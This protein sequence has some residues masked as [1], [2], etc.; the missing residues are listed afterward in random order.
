MAGIAMLE[1]WTITSLETMDIYDRVTGDCLVSLD[2]ITDVSLKNTEDKS[3]VKGKGGNVLFIIKK[4]KGLTGSGKSAYISGNLMAIQTGTDGVAG[5]ITFKKRDITKVLSAATTVLTSE[6]ADGTV[7]AEIT[8]LKVTIGDVTTAYTQATTAS[9]TKFSY[10]PL[11]KTITL[12][13]GVITADA[14]VEVV[15]NY[16]KVGASISNRTDK[17]GKTVDLEISC[18]GK[19]ICDEIYFIQ[20]SIPRADFTSVFD[21]AIGGDSTEHPFEFTGLVDK[22]PTNGGDNKL[23]DFK[24]YK[25]V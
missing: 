16:V 18:L 4:N 21:L 8:S 13:T 24:V 19:N 15:Y 25:T 9:A 1:G 14:T 11:T 7:G 6:T 17:Y 20:I 10:A 2:E 3:E 22:C 12:P 5:N 23:W